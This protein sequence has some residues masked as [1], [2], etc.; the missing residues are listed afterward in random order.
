MGCPNNNENVP[1]PGLIKKVDHVGMGLQC[2][3]WGDRQG[4]N[5][6]HCPASVAK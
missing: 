6:A 4:E 5:E 1:F 3:L 2:Q